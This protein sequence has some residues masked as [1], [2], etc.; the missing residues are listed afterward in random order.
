MD[1]P[2]I[3]EHDT[4][5]VASG[6]DRIHLGATFIVS[7]QPEVAPIGKTEIQLI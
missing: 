6:G 4:G 1:P 7:G 2:E 3:P 5:L